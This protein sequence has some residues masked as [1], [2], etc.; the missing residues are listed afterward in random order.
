MRL[1]VAIDYD[2]CTGAGACE[3]VCPE[4]FYLRDSDGLAEVIDEEP[5]ET[6]W[7]AVRRAQEACPDEAV[8]I[9]EIED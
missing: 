7:D 6:L 2:R 8:I 1:R 3:Q 5:H 4:V 9:E